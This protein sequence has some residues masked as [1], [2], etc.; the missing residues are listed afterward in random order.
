MKKGF[1][2]SYLIIL[3]IDVVAS[4]LFFLLTPPEVR[5]ATY[6]IISW[7]FAAIIGVLAAILVIGYARKDRTTRL[8]TIKTV[9]MLAFLFE[10][11]YA[12]FFILSAYV[13]KSAVVTVIGEIIITVA[14]VL[15][16]LM[17]VADVHFLR[18]VNA[19]QARVIEEKKA[20]FIHE[21]INQIEY[22]LSIANNEDIK[23]ALEDLS[24]KVAS[25]PELSPQNAEMKERELKAI[26]H[27]LTQYVALG[28]TDDVVSLVAK[29]KLKLAERNAKCH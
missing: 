21:L 11:I 13:F 5:E 28:E 4:L 18:E 2:F 10:A 15:A 3:I 22:A 9:F 6:F 26:V 20:D 19:D 1:R 14:Y 24:Y 23:K 25:S 8:I 12:L 29:A 16:F 17:K 7:S 27:Q